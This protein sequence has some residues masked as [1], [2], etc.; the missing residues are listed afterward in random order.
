MSPAKLES[1]MRSLGSRGYPADPKAFFESRPD[2]TEAERHKLTDSNLKRAADAA[3]AGAWC[4]PRCRFSPRLSL[5]RVP[6]VFGWGDC[7]LLDGPIVAIVGTRGA[8][9]YGLAAAQKFAEALAESGVCIA[10]GGALGIDA[11]AH[12]AVLKQ[13]GKT[14][15]VL[16]CGLDVAYPA[17]HRPLYKRIRESGLLLTQ[18]AFGVMPRKVSFLERNRLIAALADGVLIVEAPEHS[19]SLTVA[20]EAVELG[21]QVFVVPA[22]ISMQGFRGSHALIRSGATLVD[23]PDHILEDL[24]IDKRPVRRAAKPEA[25]GLAQ[26]ILKTLTVEPQSAEKIAAAC[27]V[28]AGAILAELTMLELDGTIIRAPGGYALRP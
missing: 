22:N 7:A 9:V 24:G 26:Q 25:K 18:F 8:S 23:H 10:S 16:P 17:V 2:L 13:G 14:L 11:S 19:G 5:S 21:K 6:C 20:H 1:M 15:A 27:H 12:E 3:K 4:L 28:E